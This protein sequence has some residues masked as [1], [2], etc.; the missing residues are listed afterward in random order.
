MIY[1]VWSDDF[2]FVPEDERHADFVSDFLD[3]SL[4]ELSECAGSMIPVNVF[5]NSMNGKKCD[6]ISGLLVGFSSMET[7]YGV[8][9]REYDLQKA[10][11]AAIRLVDGGEIPVAKNFRNEIKKNYEF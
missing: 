9:H 7:G 8:R 6:E 4:E 2:L 11:N 5:F 3:I 10:N 1:N